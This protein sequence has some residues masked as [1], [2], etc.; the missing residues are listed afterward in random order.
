M[1]TIQ[2]HQKRAKLLCRWH[3]DG[4]TSIGEKVRLLPR[5]RDLTDQEILNAPLTL[6]QAQEIVAIEAGFRNWADL[7]AHAD[8]VPA[9]PQ[10]TDATA[11]L[12]PA[13]P[14]LFVSDVPRAA[15]YYSDALGFEIDFL[16]GEPAYYGSVS[17]D[18]ACLHLRFV[19]QPNFA[20]LAARELSLIVATIEVSDVKAIFQD[21]TER[22]AEIAQKLTIQPWAGT[23]FHVRDPDGNVISF[24]EFRVN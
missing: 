22:G 16:Y 9:N 17:R 20:E 7:K 24:V 5:F 19:G 23:D 21:L 15:Q 12:S 4:N 11:H 10:D 13:I 6:M 14:I 2:T 8:P 1:P 3:R 18:S